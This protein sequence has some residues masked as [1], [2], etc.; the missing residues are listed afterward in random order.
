KKFLIHISSCSVYEGLKKNIISDKEK[1][2]N[3]KS[4]YAKSKLLGDQ[5]ILNHSQKKYFSFHI[6]RLPQVLGNNLENSSLIK[7]KKIFKFNLAFLLLSSNYFYNYILINDLKFF[8]IKLLKENN[9]NKITILSRNIKYQDLIK[10]FYKK[11]IK[12]YM[13]KTFLSDIF[14][15]FLKTLSILGLNNIKFINALTNKKIY[16]SSKRL[17]KNKDIIFKTL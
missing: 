11:E 3:P 14:Q 4:F 2:L 6:I 16:L 12:F 5:I 10:N 15:I 8:I 1:N 9:H 7:L 17:K 13:I